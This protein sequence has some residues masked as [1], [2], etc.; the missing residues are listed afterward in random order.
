MTGYN[1]I[2]IDD[3]D[4]LADLAGVPQREDHE[5]VVEMLCH[6]LKQDYR[7]LALGPESA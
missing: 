1:T 4:P 3:R 6:F 7:G 5:F 2:F